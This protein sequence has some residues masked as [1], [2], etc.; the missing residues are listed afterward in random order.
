MVFAPFKE[1]SYLHGEPE[2]TH[3]KFQL[4]WLVYW[5]IFDPDSPYSSE[6]S[7]FEPKFLVKC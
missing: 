7:P 6:K 1:I 4:E 5:P 3:A 2:K